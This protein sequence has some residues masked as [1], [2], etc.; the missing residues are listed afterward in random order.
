[1]RRGVGPAGAAR[2]ALGTLV[3]LAAV[4]PA[5]ACHAGPRPTGEPTPASS[6]GPFVYVTAQDAAEVT[7]VDATSLDVVAT[8]DLEALGYGASPR[9]HHIAVEPDGEHW[10]VSLIGANRVLKLDRSNRVV[11][12][13]EMEV[14]GMLALD[15]SSDRLYVGRSMTA[16][17]PPQRV[18]ILDRDDMSIEEISVLFPRPHA[19][20]THPARSIVYAASMAENRMAVI[21]PAEEEVEVYEIPA[22]DHGHAHMLVQWAVSPDGR[23]LVG[24]AEMSASL[25]IYDLADPLR[26]RYDRAISVDPRPWD[27]VFSPDGRELWF[28]SKGANS[29]TVVDT[30]SW[31]IDAVIHHDA[32]AEPDGAAIS[33][34]GRYVFVSSNNL[35]GEYTASAG[36]LVVIDRAT[37][38]VVRV[39]PTGAN[40]TGVGTNAR[41]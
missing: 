38:D 7:V 21:R 30:D 8:V 9:P 32:L 35:R 19:L 11:A 36:T 41:R 1:M 29:V 39:I 14:P 31:T 26:P 6:A 10:Y 20:T 33:A 12:E 5:A 25:L 34:D 2:T 23:T 4:A 24:T 16:V 37:R 40:A 27:P 28:A 17:N 15:L 3:L 13:A 22:S 18:A